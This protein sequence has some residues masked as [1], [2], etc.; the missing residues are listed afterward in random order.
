ASRGRCRFCGGWNPGV[1]GAAPARPRWSARQIALPPPIVSA[2]IGL[3]VASLLLDPKAIFSN[4]SFWNLL[5]PSQR[6]LYQLGMTGGVAWQQ[7]WWWTVL[8]AI[9]LHGSLLHIFFNMMWVRDLGP[10]VTNAYGPA[11]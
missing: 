2:C 8:T 1:L 4:F 7:G 9:Y 10:A 3:Y 5:A 6:S 11:R